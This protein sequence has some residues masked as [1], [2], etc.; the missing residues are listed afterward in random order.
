MDKRKSLPPLAALIAMFLMA[1]SATAGQFQF[2][3]PVRLKADGQVIDTGA[4]WG[5]CSP[6]VRDLNG[7]GLD[8]LV[9]GDFS[10]KFHSYLNVGKAKA[11]A[12]ASGGPIQAGGVDAEVQIYCCIGAQPRFHDLDGDG[13]RDMISNSYDPGHAYL[14]RGRPGTKFAAR[15]ELLDKAGVPI[16][17]SPVQKQNYQSFGSSF[18]AVDWEGDG[19]LDLLIGC[20]SGELKL[21]INE[22]AARSPRFAA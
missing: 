22:G 14:F 7:D 16:R 6:S 13:I 12:Y 11:P 21:R 9:V 19:D 5:H 10:G 8:D 2:E 4:A 15:E 18:E 17:S 1:G 3:S 20:F